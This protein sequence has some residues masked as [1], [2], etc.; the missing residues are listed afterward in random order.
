MIALGF[1]FEKFIDKNLYPITLRCDNNAAISCTKIQGNIGSRYS[2]EL[3]FYHMKECRKRG[4]I[5]V[6]W[7]KSKDQIADIFTKPLLF[8]L[9][10][11]LTS[12]IFNT[13]EHFVADYAEITQNHTYEEYDDGVIYDAS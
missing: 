2:T 6:K 4:K 3:R 10:E 8:T 9:H 11:K 13:N 1:S 12:K 7:V 5:A